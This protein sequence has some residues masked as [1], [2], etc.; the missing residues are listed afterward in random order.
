M[1]IFSRPQLGVAL[2]TLG[3]MLLT[4]S[5]PLVKEMQYDGVVLPFTQIETPK[6]ARQIL[7]KNQLACYAVTPNPVDL[8][9]PDTAVRQPAIAHVKEVIETAVA[10]QA[11]LVTIRNL[12]GRF[13]PVSSKEGE[14]AMF[15]TAVSHLALFAAKCNIKLTIEV[16]NRYE[17]FLCVNASETVALLNRLNQPNLG[18][19]LNA[20]HM[21]VEEQDAAATTRTVGDKL[22]L[23]YI[24]D[25]NRQAIGQG[26]LK[27]GLHLWALESVPNVPIILE[28][29]PEGSD[30][31][32]ADV[33]ENGRT[34]ILEYL[35]TS[36]SWF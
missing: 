22:T 29:L 24:A 36:R 1:E 31:F 23:F 20:F 5:A 33:G 17:S 28:C 21:N 30:P 27:L 11:P 8:A 15:E 12:P 7:Q 34:R 9:H 19:T 16:V 18:L 26:H 35:K 4:D 10:L 6:K 13:R 14:V 2:W 32:G 25:S 3:Q